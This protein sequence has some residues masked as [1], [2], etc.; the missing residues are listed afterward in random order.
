V[1]V[2]VHTHTPSHVSAVPDEERVVNN[3]WRPDRP[4]VASN[5]WA[6][7]DAACA[8]AD[9]TIAFNIAVEDPVRTTGIPSEP[10]R[11]N[12]STAAFVAAGPDRRIGFMS[13]DP[14]AAGALDEIERCHFD[15]KL[16]GIKL[17]PNYQ[18]FD[19]LGEP[20][21]AVFALASKLG[22]PIMI[23]QGAS[24]IREAEL[25]YAHPLLMDEIAITFPE[26]HVV[27]AHMGHP[28]QRDT[29]VTIR[30]HPHLYADVSALVFRPWSLYEALRL[31]TEWGVTE[32]LLLGSDFPLA[33]SA[34]T[35]AGLRGVNKILE[36]TA[37]PPV[38]AELVEGI[39]HADALGAL[40]LAGAL[41]NAGTRTGSHQ[42]SA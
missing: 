14:N 11:V 32:K 19:P 1:I 21:R 3:K 20:A 22:L 30:K 41:T 8:A 25:R 33:T 18:R 12:E 38:P 37:L 16:R 10:G 23:H 36:G 15:L 5:S 42:P 26:L 39:I 31:A 27:L 34:E 13:V 7:Y 6:D 2:D 4:V 24:P 9:V 28:W 17:A 35:I 40:G 29:I